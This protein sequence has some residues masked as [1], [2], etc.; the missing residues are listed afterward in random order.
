VTAHKAGCKCPRPIALKKNVI[1]M[2]CIKRKRLPARRLIDGP[3]EDPQAAFD[4]VMESYTNLF[5]KG[6]LVHGDL[7]PYNILDSDKGPVLIDFSQGTVKENPKATNLLFRDIKNSIP[8]FLKAGVEADVQELAE[9]IT[10][11][12]GIAPDETLII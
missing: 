2:Q 7:S 6:G 12:K 10:G 8:Y 1:V 9:G 3:T 11:E 4:G 5:Q